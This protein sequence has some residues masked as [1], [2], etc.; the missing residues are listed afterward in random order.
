M[1]KYRMFFI[2]LP[3]VM[4]LFSCSTMYVKPTIEP[5]LYRHEVPGNAELIFKAALKV[6]PMM[7]Y[8]IKGADAD[9][10]SIRTET[11]DVTVDPGDCDCGR[12]MGAPLI[13]SKGVKAKVHFIIIVSNGEIA[14]KSV[15]EPELTG[16][17][18][19]LAAAGVNFTCVSKG[20]L[21]RMFVNK[22]VDN[23]KKNALRMIFN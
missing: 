17:M 16:V 21:E 2:L 14:V 20:G 8:R 7:G 15:I 3:L 9:T 18:S 5:T 1:K 19:T 22:L 4:V 12:A 6:L 23:M 10:G 13:K 11:F